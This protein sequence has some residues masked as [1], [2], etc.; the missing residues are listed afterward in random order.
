MDVNDYYSKLDMIFSSASKIY[1]SK[2]LANYLNVYIRDMEVEVLLK[3]FNEQGRAIEIGF[4]TGE[5]L[6]RIISST[7][8]D[9]TGIDI[10]EG[11]VELARDK[12]LKL[13][14]GSH[15]KLMKMSA[16]EIG[17]IEGNFRCIY[18][19]NGALNNEPQMEKFIHGLWERL[20][21]GGYFVVSIRNRYSLG[22]FL[23]DIISGRP[24]KI[25]ERL[26]GEVEVE[27]VGK[28]VMSHYF[29]PCEF[30]K[31]LGKEFDLIYK[32]GLSVLFLP[33][34]YE[35]VNGMNMKKIVISLEKILS[36]IP[37][38]KD[39]GDEIIFVFK[40]K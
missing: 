33:K 26:K 29:S 7:G 8:A 20:S 10:S 35:K 27:V 32:R 18:S 28:N 2:I 37:I 12:L 4:G 11:M 17:N 14:L 38:F 25:R 15:F 23:I 24:D 1:D 3:Y 36:Q 34:I 40:K 9:V 39:M 5:E 22:E 6:K 31:M 19:F 21:E 16:S 30:R 13:G